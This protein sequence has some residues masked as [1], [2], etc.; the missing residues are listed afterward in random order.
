MLGGCKDAIL[1]FVNM[2]LLFFE[3]IILVNPTINL[4][5]PVS[6]GSGLPLFLVDTEIRAEI[7]TR[8]CHDDIEIIFATEGEGEVFYDFEYVPLKKN[9]FCIVNSNIVHG[10]KSDSILKFT[11]IGISNNFFASNQINIKDLTFEKIF[12]DPTLKKKLDKLRK[13]F[14]EYQHS[15][16][17]YAEISTA[18]LEFS[19]YLIKKHSRTK[20]N[21]TEQKDIHFAINYIKGNL[22]KKLTLDEIASQAGLSKYYFSREFKKLTGM[23]VIDYINY[24]RCKQA[25]SYLSSKMYSVKDVFELTCFENFSYFTRIFKRNIGMLPSEFLKKVMEE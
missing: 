4:S 20:E 5:I 10:A 14:Y 21:L 1:L 8:N 2:I 18:L 7:H 16:Y 9:E 25:C 6:V 11:N 13:A 23:T 3:V 12:S 19:L 15:K 17:A 22:N 24:Y